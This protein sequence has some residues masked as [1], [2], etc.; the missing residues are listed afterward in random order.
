MHEKSNST[1]W[2]YDKISDSAGILIGGKQTFSTGEEI[3]VLGELTTDTGG[4]LTRNAVYSISNGEK[5][6]SPSS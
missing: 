5:S 6:A 4:T 2:Q 3:M 1:A